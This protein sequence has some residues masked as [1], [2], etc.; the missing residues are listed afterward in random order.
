MAKK[1]Y[2]GVGG[3]ARKVKKG[4]VGISGFSQPLLTSDGTLG[5][6]SFAVSTNNYY[7][8]EYA[9]YKAFNG[10]LGDGYSSNVNPSNQTIYLTFY[11]PAALSVSELRFTNV[12][13]GLT[14]SS[15]KDFSVQGSNDNSSWVTIGSF[16][17]TNNTNGATWPISLSGGFYKYHRL[18]ITSANT[19]QPYV[20]IGEISISATSESV[21]RQIKKVYIGIGGGAV[22]REVQYIESSGTQCINTGFKA[23]Q[24]TRVRVEAEAT[25]VLTDSIGLFGGRT[26][27]TSK[28]FNFW[29]SVK[30]HGARFDYGAY[31]GDSENKLPANT[32]IIVDAD[33]GNC[34]YGDY[35]ET[36]THGA[37]QCD[38][39]IALFAIN[40]GGTIGNFFTGRIYPSQIYDNGKLAR[41]YVPV[42]GENNVAGMFDKVEKRFY[43]NVGSGNFVAGPETGITHISNGVARPCWSGG[44]PTYYG[45]ITNITVGR[46]APCSAGYNNYAIFGPGATLS[47]TVDAYNKSLVKTTRDMATSVN[48]CAAAANGTHGMIYG[49]KKSSGTSSILTAYD[50]SFTLKKSEYMNYVAYW[51]VGVSF[52]ANALFS[53][54]Y[55]GSSVIGTVL[56]VN[57]NLTVSYPVTLNN[58]YMPYANGVGAAT[59]K[60]A[61]WGGGTLSGSLSGRS[62]YVQGVNTS[63]TSLGIKELSEAK[64]GLGAARAGDYVVFAGGNKAIRTNTV[65]AFNSSMTKIVCDPLSAARDGLAGTNLGEYALFAGGYTTEYSPIVDIYDSSLVH[66]VGENIGEGR[67]SMGAAPVGEFAL[68]A[69]GSVGSARPQV[70]AYT[71]A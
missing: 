67:G 19:T 17:N 5:G 13:A 49:G 66:T 30:N 58:T 59:D 53:G 62:K 63:F 50:G 34:I 64:Q 26:S 3:V 32:R 21:A 31:D 35:T 68:F 61:L 45:E 33:K 48:Y 16:T 52:G 22:Y 27:A 25:T 56:S 10:N 37:F 55:N 46:S 15:P 20:N 47:T 24:N 9:A 7:S 12:P 40:T 42:V 8:A 65:D 29:W 2:I 39:P 69:G 60:I 41:D 43:G 44:S 51:H 36:N 23:N 28:A 14:S 11:N 54:G 4:Y 18:A 6:N 1:A 38:Y 71:I 70:Y 57:Q